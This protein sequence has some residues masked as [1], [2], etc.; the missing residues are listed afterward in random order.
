VTT[1]L[2]KMTRLGWGPTP[3]NLM[4]AMGWPMIAG[5]LE[6]SAIREDGVGSSSRGPTLD[7]LLGKVVG[8]DESNMTSPSTLEPATLRRESVTGMTGARNKQV[9]INRPPFLQRVTLGPT[10][11]G[12]DTWKQN[13]CRDPWLDERSPKGF[14]RC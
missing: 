1:L 3:T 2:H 9:P 14:K 7:P 13:A 8:E 4:A 5:T 6:A 10:G 12:E 11:R